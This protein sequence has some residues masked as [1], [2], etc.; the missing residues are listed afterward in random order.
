[1][2]RSQSSLLQWVREGEL[3]HTKLDEVYKIDFM[4]A[5]VA[6]YE[7]S[8]VNYKANEKEGAKLE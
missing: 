6:C 3:E 2:Q 8:G 5:C 1:M 7:L 4:P